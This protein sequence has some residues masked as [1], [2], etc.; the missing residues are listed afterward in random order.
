MT[1]DT[2]ILRELYRVAERGISGAALAER[3]GVSRAA[4][5]SRIDELRK[6]GFEIDASPH[7][8]YR[9][10][11]SPDRLFGD[12][13]MARLPE[14]IVIGRQIQV[15]KETASTNEIA[16]RLGRDGVE[17]GAVVLSEFQSKG[18]GR[19]GRTW[20]SPGGKGILMSVLLRPALRPPEVTRL[21]IIGATAAVRAIER[22]TT[23]RPSI[24]WPNDVMMGSR[25]LAGILTEMNAEPDRVR[26]V[27][28]GIGLNVNQSR[29][30]FPPEL[31]GISGSLNLEAGTLV[32]RPALAAAM[33]EE[34]DR[35][36]HR[37]MNGGFT[38][39]AAEWQSKCGTLGCE[40]SVQFGDSVVKGLAEA[41]D[42]DGALLVRTEG[43]VIQRITGGDVSLTKG[44]DGAGSG[45]V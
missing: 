31:D 35:D 14:G 36:Y 26:Y 10:V 9:L 38:E 17:E 43:G 30:D 21:T 44:P 42:E 34:L 20:F 32:D 37:V 33:I 25:K 22:C 8:G 29:E 4:I 28:V 41:I 5:W 16:E 15:F 2:K 3:M 19:L 11:S 23:V 13:L 45:N 1:R 27:V 6:V 39:V 18:R 40:V 12:D 24:K 7:L